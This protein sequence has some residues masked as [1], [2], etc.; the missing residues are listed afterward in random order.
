MAPRVRIPTPTPVG[1]PNLSLDRPRQPVTL[2]GGETFQ[3]SVGGRFAEAL[4][5]GA[6][7]LGGGLGQKAGLALTRGSRA[8]DLEPF[9]QPFIDAIETAQA[10]GV[11]LN[12]LA[13][14]LAASA[15]ESPKAFARALENPELLSQVQAIASLVPGGPETGQV[16]VKS[17]FVTADG[18][19]GALLEDP[20]AP[21]GVRFE[22]SDVSVDPNA[23]ILPA[24]PGQVPTIVARRGEQ[25]GV[26]QPVLPAGSLRR[27]IPEIGQAASRADQIIAEM[28]RR[29]SAGEPEESV[30]AFGAQAFAEMSAQAAPASPGAPPAGPGVQGRAPTAEEAE[31]GRL[32][33][34]QAL[35]PK[36]RFAEIEA[37][38]QAKSF[39][40]IQERGQ[41]AA[42]NKGRVQAIMELTE[43]A[44]T[45]AFGELLLSAQ[46]IGLR[47]PGLK[48]FIPTE[49]VAAQE[50]IQN[51]NV[52]EAVE[53]LREHTGPK[54]DFET[55][56]ALSITPGLGQTPEGNK[57]LLR[58]RLRQLQRDIDIADLARRFK[59]ENGNLDERFD[60]QVA[61]LVAAKPLF[62]TAEQEFLLRVSPAFRT[63]SEE[64][65]ADVPPQAAPQGSLEEQLNAEFPGVAIRIRPGQ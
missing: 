44:P 51:F 28:N 3:T 38:A 42:Q 24:Q 15:K 55:R 30:E 27:E 8:K 63:L 31:L 37:E 26:A 32:R 57:M 35:N 14:G 16:K 17:G 61:A 40:A 39:R 49:G 1:V 19:Q 36:I 4:G 5:P 64:L 46:R 6:F 12:P 2:G 56:M 48:G 34:Q 18:K 47:I 11:R 52:T 22:V 41:A 43:Q 29:I 33:A 25:A 9:R 59:A 23:Q 65:G 53:T 58:A 50:F 13:I 54:S 45:G 20:N 10:E 60:A 62:D 21:G 7:A